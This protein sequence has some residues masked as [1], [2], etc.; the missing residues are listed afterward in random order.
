MKNR[1]NYW[2][3]IKLFLGSMLTFPLG[4]AFF[5]LDYNKT[6]A[7][8]YAFMLYGSVFVM[9]IFLFNYLETGNII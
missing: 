7:F 1:I 2:V 9:G 8:W 4:W 5:S 6:T 3:Y